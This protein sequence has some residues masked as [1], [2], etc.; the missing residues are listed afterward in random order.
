MNGHKKVVRKTLKKNNNTKLHKHNDCKVA[1]G[2]GLPR[3]FRR[4]FQSYL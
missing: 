4:Y 1:G 2:G 3:L